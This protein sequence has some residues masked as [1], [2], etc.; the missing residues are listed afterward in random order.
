MFNYCFIFKCICIAEIVSESLYTTYG[1]K[2]SEVEIMFHVSTML[3]YNEID[4]QQIDRKRHI[5]NDV[6]VVIFKETS[7][8][9]DVVD[10]C[11]FRSHF[12]HV[13][14][15]VTP[16]LSQTALHA[17]SQSNPVEASSASLSSSSTASLPVAPRLLTK[18]SVSVG[19]K[20]TV[21]P[22]PPHFSENGNVF[23]IGDNLKDWLL[24][25][26]KIFVY[27]IIILIILIFDFIILL[28][29][30]IIHSYKW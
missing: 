27:L 13:F 4:P 22:F 5:G 28:F 3:P 10:L 30:F 21:K 20:G 17:R 7:G 15:V 23:D 19:C 2:D 8:P 16:I 6:V 14:I 12:N 1:G 24:K 25:K 9:D 11:S 29:V 26:S 18:Y